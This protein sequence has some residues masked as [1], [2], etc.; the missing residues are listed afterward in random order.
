MFRWMKEIIDGIK[1]AR[2]Q[3]LAERE[4]DAFTRKISKFITFEIWPASLKYKEEHGHLPKYLLL[5]MD[6]LADI[7]RTLDMRHH[8][9]PKDDFNKV[10]DIEIAWNGG[11]G[12]EGWSFSDECPYEDE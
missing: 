10:C 2:G 9:L 3:M 7:H 4:E 5:P 8:N 12:E 6:R 1:W 11:E